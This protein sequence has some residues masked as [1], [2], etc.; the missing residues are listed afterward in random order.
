M[1]TT[2][3]RMNLNVQWEWW[4]SST[5]KEK[6]DE[7][8]PHV[9][10]RHKPR[11]RHGAASSSVEGP[12]W[13]QPII[14]ACG[15]G[16]EPDT[17]QASCPTCGG[18]ST[19]SERGTAANALYACLTF[20]G[21]SSG[22]VGEGAHGCREE[23][24][25]WG[26]VWR[27]WQV[28]MM[29]WGGGKRTDRQREMEES[30]DYDKSQRCW[31]REENRWTT[32]RLLLSSRSELNAREEQT[33]TPGQVKAT[34]DVQKVQGRERLRFDLLHLSE[35][36]QACRVWENCSC[37]SCPAVELNGGAAYGFLLVLL[38]DL[39]SICFP[40]RRHLLLSEARK[41]EWREDNTM[42]WWGV[43]Q[44]SGS[45]RERGHAGKGWDCG[46]P[47]WRGR[48]P[49]AHGPLGGWPLVGSVG[50]GEMN[51]LTKMI[52][53]YS[54]LALQRTMTQNEGMIAVNRNICSPWVWI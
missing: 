45:W 11:P 6:K 47:E 37:D 44:R 8:I 13:E 20:M 25:G 51:S 33:V 29:S 19:A 17:V 31:R 7:S 27:A 4:H 38:K 40:A 32:W 5:G 46:R 52:H 15:C 39:G 24:A 34:T 53:D 30:A 36:I 21:K 23:G 2:D 1:F 43:L 42:W 3:G 48:S 49:G 18:S 16:G 10:A 14:T 35:P 22:E 50:G 26:G 54:P 9:T 28:H 12:G 41:Q